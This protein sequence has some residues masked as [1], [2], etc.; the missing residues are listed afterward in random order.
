MTRN[1]CLIGLPTSGKSI[2][3]T[4]LY[5]YLN[6]DF[7]NT[8][9]LIQRKYS[10]PLHDIINKQGSDKFLDIESNIIKSLK[11]K[12]VVIATGGSVIYRQ[13]TINYIKDWF[14]TDI[15]HLFISKDEFIK[16]ISQLNDYGIIIPENQNLE[17]V[18]E[19]RIRLYN[20]FTD[21]IINANNDIN[22][23]SFQKPMYSTTSPLIYFTRSYRS[24]PL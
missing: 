24:P 18:Y 6:K 17:Q 14:N 2:I 20:T 5:K 8:N 16:R 15:Y 21:Y 1:I 12:N 11:P 22:L 4:Q 19:H 13:N 23:D 10:C 3:G 9:Q 7:I